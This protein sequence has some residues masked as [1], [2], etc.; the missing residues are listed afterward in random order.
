M[1]PAKRDYLLAMTPESRDTLARDCRTSLRSAWPNRH[2]SWRAKA[3]V[4]ANV[5]MLRDL[6]TLT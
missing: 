3:V 6:S 5:T 2:T 4:Q 1:S